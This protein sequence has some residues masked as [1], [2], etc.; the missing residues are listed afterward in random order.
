MG[1]DRN[2]LEGIAV[3]SVGILRGVENFVCF[4]GR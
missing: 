2:R 1:Q 3:R 4:K